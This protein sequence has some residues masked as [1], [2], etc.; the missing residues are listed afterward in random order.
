MA[1]VRS[2]AI[3]FFG[4]SGDLARKQIFPALQGLVTR[5]G[6]D[7]PVIGVA[8]S[9][10]RLDQ[11]RERARESL[12]EH[13]LFDSV[14]F[15]KL[16]ALLRYVDGD[17]AD[18]GTFR[19]LRSIL[20]PARRPLHYLAIPPAAFEMVANGLADANCAP[21]AR[22]V[23]EK[24]FGRDLRSAQALN[25][26][27]HEHFAE[28]SIYR[29]DHFLGKEPVQNILYT[30][31][32]NSIFEPLW[33][34]T[35][36]RSIQITMAEAFGINGRGRFYEEAGAI[37]DVV[38]NHLLQVLAFVAMDAPTGEG[39]EAMHLEKARLLK[40]IRSLAPADCVRGQFRGYRQEDGVAPDSQVE[41]F[42]AMRFLIE[43]W[44]WADVPF[45]VRT[46][47]R[48]PLTMT[49]V[50]VQF[51]RPPR[52]TFGES[53]PATSNHLRIR[54]DP[55]VTI[56]LG[57]RVKVPGESMSGEDLELIT[58]R[59]TGA[60]MSPYERLLGDALNGDRTLFATEQA[61]EEQWRIA[62]P[63]L[64]NSAPLLEYEAGTWG[65][66]DADHLIAPDGEWRP[67]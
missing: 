26:V 62:E 8:K 37:R 30:R 56:G 42:A 60:D 13:G 36:I 65:P 53:V 46:G 17:Y 43:T 25:A 57:V 27:L 45:Y 50:L 47:K 11:L 49:E 58:T 38:Q 10:W 41:T 24:P 14:Q 64:G 7:A 16:D 22:V 39:P 48:L 35:H 5:H 15:A 23:V 21:N 33:N 9:G 2:D 52:E 12:S 31:F 61:V 63:V 3:V 66:S 40:A 4:A 29:I 34:R 32:A 67:R 19:E 51:H 54:L 1:P 55:D 18:A 44:R 59:Q 20:G 28:E 6:L